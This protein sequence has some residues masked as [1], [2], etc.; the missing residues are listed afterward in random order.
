V[1][2]PGQ[3]NIYLLPIPGRGWLIQQGQPNTYVLPEPSGGLIAVAAFF[4]GWFDW[5]TG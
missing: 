4:G 5:A 2:Q 1:I 3:P